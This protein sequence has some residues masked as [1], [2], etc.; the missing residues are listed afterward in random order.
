MRFNLSHTLAALN[1]E[2]SGVK[3]PTHTA[4]LQLDSRAVKA[5]DV[6]I[7]IK[8]HVSN[9]E[10]FISAA[11]KNGASCALV[12]A[13]RFKAL[14][15]SL[16]LL[17]PVDNL[18]ERIAEIAKT[19]YQ[20]PTE[21][22]KVIGVTGTNGKST[23]TAMI[24]ALADAIDTPAA[25]VGT[26][27]YGKV[28]D[29]TPL[30]NTTPSAVDLQRIF[31]TLAEHNQLAAIEVSSHGLVQGRVKETQFSTAVYTNLSRDHLDYH[32][33][34]HSYAQAKRL[35]FTE[36]MPK[37]CVLNH[38]DAVAQSWIVQSG[39]S[40]LVVYGKKPRAHNFTQFVWFDEV[41]CHQAGIRATLS[42]S[43]GNATIN[44]PLFGQFNLYNL[45][46]AM[47]ALLVEGYDFRA[48]C[49]AVSSLKPVAGRMQAFSVEGKPTCVVDYA[50]TPDALAL[51]LQAL[52]QHVPGQVTCVF[53]CGGDRDKG[54]RPMMAQAA[55]QNADKLVITSDNPRSENPDDII[56]DVKAG[57]SQPEYAYCQPDRAKAIAYAVEQT[58]ASGVVLV[59]GKGH[60]D[61]QIIGDQTITFC[62]R[63][64]VMKILKGDKA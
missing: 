57:L 3:L 13:T 11:F 44:V 15:Q 64:W 30:Q 5:N 54:K 49:N 33:D 29:L 48:L 20:S 22:L 35:L 42:T 25:V 10:N 1:I 31:A 36:C 40:D 53:G 37:H 16:G 24:A 14:D 19:Y 62:D 60:E 32:G 28:D 23:T 4:D 45:A 56:A 55:E 47:A 43:W 18:A 41:E 26:L 6:F 51:A 63:A 7:A 46:A 21:R 27:G 58:S 12:D 34:M 9:G 38:D 8:G 61:Y 50:H 17:I 52:Q 59:A 39:F 2:Y